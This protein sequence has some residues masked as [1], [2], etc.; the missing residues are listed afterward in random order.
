[1]FF[2]ISSNPLLC[3]LFM[4]YTLALNFKGDPVETFTV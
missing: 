4:S 2:D 3:V 1:M